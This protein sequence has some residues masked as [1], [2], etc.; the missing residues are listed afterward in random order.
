MTR[1]RKAF[2]L[3][4]ISLFLV[5]F[6]YK[7]Y[8]S[9]E[10]LVDEVKIKVDPSKYG[11]VE[12]QHDLSNASIR[13]SSNDQIKDSSNELLN[14]SVHL[15][16][17]ELGNHITKESPP[18]SEREKEEFSSHF[19]VDE[20]T[21]E[22]EELLTKYKKSKSA[23]LLNEYF[24]VPIKYDGGV[25]FAKISVEEFG[26]LRKNPGNVYNRRLDYLN[27]ADSYGD[28]SFDAELNATELF[29]TYFPHSD[30]DILVLQCRER[31]CLTEFT[32]SNEDNAYQFIDT[33]RAKRNMC[34]CRVLEYFPPTGNQ[35]ILEI[36]FIN[37]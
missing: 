10:V 12:V 2:G 30:Y 17:P 22:Y 23:I 8:K 37:T 18:S 1:A 9:G 28:W 7:H 13:D 25:D 29:S 15:K 31:F 32:F 34:Q 5:F 19:Y 16:S 20:N 27:K 21:D 26:E 6:A 14:S 36:E 35:A 3:I 24:Y 11:R 33:L 4:L